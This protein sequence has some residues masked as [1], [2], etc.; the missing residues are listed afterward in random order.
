LAE[1]WLTVRTEAVELRVAEPAVTTPPVG[2][3]GAA[4][5]EPDMAARA[6]TEQARKSALRRRRRLLLL[7][8]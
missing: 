5:A 7:V 1:V 2:S 4:H 3:T 6:I 8:I